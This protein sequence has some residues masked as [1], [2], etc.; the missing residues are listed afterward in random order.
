MSRKPAGTLIEG[1][2]SQPRRFLALLPGSERFVD[3]MP[4]S[5]VDVPS[6]WD[7]AGDRAEGE[8]AGS[9]LDLTTREDAF[10]QVA[11]FNR[12]SLKVASG[13]TAHWGIVIE[14]GSARVNPWPHVYFVVEVTR[15]GSN[16]RQLRQEFVTDVKIVRPTAEERAQYAIPAGELVGAVA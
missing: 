14:V 16:R 9:S 12:K 11:E 4:K 6:E 15:D 10:K 13:V 3:K 5:Y 7:S 8:F 1:S 2:E